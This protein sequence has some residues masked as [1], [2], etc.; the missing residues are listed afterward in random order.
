MAVAEKKAEDGEGDLKM[1]YKIIDEKDNVVKFLFEDSNHTE[2]NFIRRTIMFNVPVMAIEDVYFT[3]NTSPLYDEIIAQRLGLI[4][5]STDIITYNQPEACKCKG[6]GCAKCQVK[7]SA[8][9][10]GPGTFYAKDLKTTDPKI[11]PIYPNMLI[12]KLGKNQ[13]IV[14]EAVAVLGKGKEH[15]KWSPALVYYIN[16]PEVK[17]DQKKA[18]K[19]K[20][21]ILEACSSGVIIENSGK[22]EVDKEI[23]L[24]EELASE[25]VKYVADKYDGI[26][27]NDSESE[28]VMTIESWGQLSPKELLKKSQELIIKEINSAK[29]K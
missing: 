14:F 7:L 29:L 16:K 21:Q 19:N 3:K 18:L 12:T 28:F 1:K 22:L 24:K 13:E 20:K 11:K 8:S 17:I 4:P 27:V 5:L 10:K 6:K 25:Q 26:N 15:M 23:L 9:L 2:M